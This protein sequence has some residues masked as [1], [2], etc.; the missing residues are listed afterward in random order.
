MMTVF[1]CGVNFRSISG[2]EKNILIEDNTGQTCLNDSVR[3]HSCLIER[4]VAVIG[5]GIAL[6]QL[7]E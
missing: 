1:S 6:T 4:G 3:V 7:T 2:L 5:D